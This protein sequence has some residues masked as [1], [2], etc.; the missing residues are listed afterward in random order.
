MAVGDCNGHGQG[1]VLQ[2]L[3]V[4][5]NPGTGR[6]QQLLLLLDLSSAASRPQTTASADGTLQATAMDIA[7]LLLKHLQESISEA[8][9]LSAHTWCAAC[10]RSSNGV[11]LAVLVWCI[12]RVL[13]SFGDHSPDCAVGGL[14]RVLYRVVGSCA[15]IL[16]SSI[17]L[18]FLL[19]TSLCVQVCVSPW[20]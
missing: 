12:M 15:R 20:G 7:V 5:S 9:I 19:T 8:C 18:V 13:D 6:Q 17:M 11:V 4:I 1:L 3:R 10:H 14:C 2:G 16:K